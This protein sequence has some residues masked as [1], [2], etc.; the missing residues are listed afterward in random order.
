MNMAKRVNI[1]GTY[2]EVRERSTSAGN[3]GT[4][5]KKWSPSSGNSSSAQ[6]NAG[7]KGAAKALKNHGKALEWLGGKD[8]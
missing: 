8:R 2:M 1:G 5:I 7:K 6:Y 3:K 4:F